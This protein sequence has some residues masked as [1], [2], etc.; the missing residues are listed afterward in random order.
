M[1]LASSLSRRKKLSKRKSKSD[2]KLRVEGL[3]ERQLLTELVVTVE[4][5]SNDD[6]LFETPFWVGFHDGSFDLG[7]QG[8]SADNFGGLEALAEE[9]DT[10]GVSARFAEE[11]NGIDTT[12]TSPGGFA[13]APVFDPGEVV[14]TTIDVPNP[15]EN[16]YFSFASMVIPSNDS[17]LAN[18]DRYAHRIFTGS[19]RFR[20]TTTINLFGANVYDAG[21]EVN[22]PFGGAAFSTEGGDS[23]VEGGV[24]SRTTSLDDFVGTGI[25]TGD[26]LGSAFSRRT[27]LARI[28]LSL[29]SDPSEPLDRRGPKADLNTETTHVVPGSMTHTVEVTYHDPSGVDVES[30]DPSDIRLRAFRGRGYIRPTAVTTDAADGTNPTSVVATYTFEAPGGEF[31]SR[32][33]GFYRVDLNRNAD[34]DTQGNRNRRDRLGRFYVDVPAQVEVTIENLA[35]EGGLSLTPFWVGFHNGRFDL[36]TSGRS[37]A[38]FIGLEE[39]AEGGDTSVLSDYFNDTTFGVDTTIT[40]PEGFGGAPILEPGESATAA[41]DVAFASFNRYFSYASMVI[42]SNDAFIGNLFSR[43]NPV[44]DYG[45]RVRP[46]TITVY[47]NDIY[48]AGTEVND[49]QGGAAFSTEGGE[50]ADE[51]GVIHRHQGLD[52]F[53]GTGTL[54]GSLMQAFSGRTPIARI[55]IRAV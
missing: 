24:I 30:I 33:S 54:T 35:D 55:S 46:T 53:V 51:N 1:D 11:S 2:R 32:D 34:E 28:T 3:E 40:A 25:P 21:T 6:G 5:L 17:F 26:E 8:K 49:P 10:S 38:G 23:V 16:Q 45:G 39:I 15:S 12:I 50:S 43:E 37:A 41:I 14:Q 44:F 47:G 48:D 13:G 22:N 42:P 4:N 18:L 31:D 20:G 27:P 19:G 52:N 29:A 9:G 36:G 7:T